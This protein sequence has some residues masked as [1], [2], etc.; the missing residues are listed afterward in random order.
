MRFEGRV[1][2]TG[3]WWAI[4]VALLG[5]F[6]QGRSKRAAYDAIK[7]AI[8]ELANSSSFKIDVFPDKGEYFEV[9]SR[10]EATLIA[11]LLKRQRQMR[12]LSLAEVS[13]RMGL[14][15]RNAYAR[16]EQGKAVPTV[17]KLVEL[18]RAVTLKENLSSRRVPRARAKITSRFWTPIHPVRSTKPALSTL[19][20]REPSPKVRRTLA[21]EPTGLRQ[22]QYRPHRRQ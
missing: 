10:G 4:E 22:A 13:E 18:L 11:F 20:G 9:G 1:F 6:T 3:N 15:S 14:K 2:K 8:E 7:N 12:G 21:A 16:Y 19:R 17:D 5:V